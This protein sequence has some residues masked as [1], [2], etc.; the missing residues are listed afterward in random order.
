[1]S[2]PPLSCKLMGYRS[3]H[4]MVGKPDKKMPPMVET[5]IL[6]GSETHSFWLLPKAARSF[7]EDL[8][9]LADEADATRAART[10]AVAAISAHVGVEPRRRPLEARSGPPPITSAEALR[11]VKREREERI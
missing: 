3:L 8:M 1:M 6:D 10:G 7:A 11:K 9:Q 5:S 2:H 4:A